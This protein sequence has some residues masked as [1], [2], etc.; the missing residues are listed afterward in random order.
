MRRQPMR[1]LLLK[2]KVDEDVV[3][4]TSDGDIRI[5]VTGIEQD[6]VQLLFDAPQ[7]VVI[8]RAE[9]DF[10][11]ADFIGGVLASD[12]SVAAGNS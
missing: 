12:D 9:I 1:G 3:L 6:R 10:T 11:E 8:L 4:H 2:R 5:R 7:A